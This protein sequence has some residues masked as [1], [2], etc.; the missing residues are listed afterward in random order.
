M[1][2]DENEFVKNFVT[3]QHF[4]DP[5]VMRAWRDWYSPDAVVKRRQVRGEEP[6][7][8]PLSIG[9]DLMHLSR[10]MIA[11]RNAKN[12]Q[13]S[14]RVVEFTRAIREAI[15]ADDAGNSYDATLFAAIHLWVGPENLFISR[16]VT[17]PYDT[18]NRFPG[19]KGLQWENVGVDRKPKFVSMVLLPEDVLEFWTMFDWL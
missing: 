10:F 15:Y 3:L 5:K 14:E 9:D 7:Y 17:A 8:L 2:L 11:I 19:G 6:T 13:G 16:E 18:E 12:A 1:N 4:D